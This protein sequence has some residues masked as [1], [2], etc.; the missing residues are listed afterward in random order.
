[1]KK[2]TGVRDERGAC[3]VVVLGAGDAY[4][5]PERRD[6][7]PFSSEGFNWGHQGSGPTQLAL[8]ILADHLR[9]PIRKP[10]GPAPEAGGSL[11]CAYVYRFRRLFIEPITKPTWQISEEDVELAVKE[12]LIE[13]AARGA[14]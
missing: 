14:R 13:D 10:G 7:I 3:T 6:L 8:A 2:Y 4:N 11:A 12:F 9:E 1:M 5:L